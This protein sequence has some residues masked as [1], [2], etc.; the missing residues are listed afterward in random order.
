MTR[1]EIEN[2]VKEI[3]AVQFGMMVDEVDFESSFVKDLNADSL[4]AV[5]TTMMAEDH[6][7]INIADE[8]AEK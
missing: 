7:D 2:K 1:T 5:E 3:I 4:D 8:E 6:F